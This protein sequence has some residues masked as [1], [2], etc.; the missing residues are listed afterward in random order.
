MPRP[1]SHTLAG[2]AGLAATDAVIPSADEARNCKEHAALHVW[3]EGGPEPPAF[4]PPAESGRGGGAADE[5]S[6]ALPPPFRLEPGAMVRVRLILEHRHFLH[7]PFEPLL[8]PRTLELHAGP[9]EFRDELPLDRPLYVAQAPS[10]W[11]PPPADRL[12]GRQFVSAPDS[13]YLAADLAGRHSFDFPEQPVRYGT[14]MRLSFWYLIAPGTRGTCRAEIRQYREAPRSYRP[15]TDGRYDQ[16]LEVVGRWARF[17]H[18]YRTEPEANLLKL[19]FLVDSDDEVG[20]MWIDD[21]LLEPLGAAP[22]GP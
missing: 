4:A 22:E 17:E 16:P 2:S 3:P 14:P 18:V 13:L 8:G 19:R 6:P 15:L 12:D 10:T 11:G 7:G 21:V 20:E 1:V 9:G 5:G